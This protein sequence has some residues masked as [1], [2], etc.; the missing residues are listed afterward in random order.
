MY[1]PKFTG[2]AV[3]LRNLLL[4]QI[5]ILA[6]GC[7]TAPHPAGPNLVSESLPHYEI[8][9]TYVYSNGSSETVTGIS[10]QLVTWRDHRGNVYHRSR[11]FTYR[12][13]SWKTSARKG[14]RRFE[15]FSYSYVKG[16]N[17]LWPLQKGNLSSFKE[18]V[19]S[20]KTGEPEKS[21]Q[22]NWECEVIGTERITVMAGEFDT[23]KIA[24]KRYNNFQEPW[25]ARVREIKTWNYVPLFNRLILF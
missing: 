15:T 5:L 10:P 21:Y 20:N 9:T 2:I 16:N 3:A 19:T 14:S 23:W 17:S 8:G 4:F 25:E 24:C 11:D 12:A 22:V 18:R 13:V 6:M 1:K 7:S